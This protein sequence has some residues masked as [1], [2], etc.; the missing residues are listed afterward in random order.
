MVLKIIEKVKKK[1]MGWWGNS[2]FG[3]KDG[4]RNCNG[5]RQINQL[6]GQISGK[7]LM[8]IQKIDTGPT[9]KQESV[10][11][12]DSFFTSLLK[13][14]SRLARSPDVGKLHHTCSRKVR[15]SLALWG[16]VKDFLN[17][18][19]SSHL[20]EKRDKFNNTT[21]EGSILCNKIKQHEIQATVFEAL[22]VEITDR[23]ESND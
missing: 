3:C 11:E 2:A 4:E 22:C 23:G 13:I 15:P 8:W 20:Q 7:T 14:N 12:T 18:Q 19:R 16:E 1:W 9:W 10:G 21:M 6:C 17:I 5:G